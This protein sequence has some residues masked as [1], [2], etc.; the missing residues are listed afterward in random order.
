[1]QT[2]FIC[3]PMDLSYSTLLPERKVKQP[4]GRFQAQARPHNV[5]KALPLMGK[6]YVVT[7]ITVE[8]AVK[9]APFYPRIQWLSYTASS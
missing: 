8:T 4:E 3:C 2:R 7:N 6:T 5:R 9:E 1:M